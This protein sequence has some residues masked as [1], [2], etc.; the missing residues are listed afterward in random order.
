M[1]II[2]W[3]SL[4]IAQCNSFIATKLTHTS[5]PCRCSE[6]L[7]AACRL[8]REE[9][10]TDSQL[11]L[12]PD[13]TGGDPGSATDLEL[14]SD[15]C[16]LLF[17]FWSLH[18]TIYLSPSK[19]SCRWNKGK[20]NKLDDQDPFLSH[21]LF[22]CCCAN[23]AAGLLPFEAELK[24]CEPPGSNFAAHHPL[25][26]SGPSAPKS[27]PSCCY[28]VLLVGC[29]SLFLTDEL[30]VVKFTA[31]WQLQKVADCALMVHKLQ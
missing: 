6:P 24:V 15:D 29:I 21:P 23:S 12:L 9:G 31:M 28:R 26:V 25:L 17:T 19:C 10:E 18:G 13:W 8:S 27:Q 2:S 22:C 30:V 11:L 4:F 5:F 16:A 7:P 20:K 3:E 1:I 14:Q